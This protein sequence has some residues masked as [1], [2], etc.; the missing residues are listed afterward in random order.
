VSQATVV[1]V[2]GLNFNRTERIGILI[3]NLLVLFVR[4]NL[5]DSLIFDAFHAHI[6]KRVL[7]NVLIVC[8]LFLSEYDRHLNLAIIRKKIN[9]NL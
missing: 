2:N 8:R 3:G 1:E 6:D 9:Y 7:N 4:E 5:G